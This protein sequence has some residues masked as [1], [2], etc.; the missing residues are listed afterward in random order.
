M[1][2]LH[3][4]PDWYEGWIAA[5]SAVVRRREVASELEQAIESG[6]YDSVTF[7][8]LIQLI[9]HERLCVDFQQRNEN[10]DQHRTANLSHWAE[11]A[12]PKVSGCLVRSND[13]S[14]HLERELQA[15]LI[16]S[17]LA[18]L[19]AQEKDSLHT[20]L[21]VKLH[22]LFVDRYR[23]LQWSPHGSRTC[24]RESFRRFQCSYLLCAGA[25]YAK[26]F[27]QSEPLL[28]TVASRITSIFFSALSIAS[29]A[30]VVWSWT[31]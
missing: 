5:E 7:V 27:R 20:D 11:Q 4:V 12:T 16:L 17:L 8:E 26:Q 29:V 15:R 6:H 9:N 13:P 2:R 1:D 23:D 30:T 10:S 3:R 18:L 25:E 31:R 28:A 14:S 22:S 19:R 24:S 21:Y